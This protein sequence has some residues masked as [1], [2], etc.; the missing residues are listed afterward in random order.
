MCKVLVGL[1]QARSMD[2]PLDHLAA[3]TSCF[4][5]GSG[6]W[7]SEGGGPAVCPWRLCECLRVKCH[8]EG[9]RSPSSPYPPF[10]SLVLSPDSRLL[11]HLSYCA[12]V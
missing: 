5:N 4:A 12:N 2:K 7:C 1:V 8:L 6:R 11:P 9:L 10:F 3:L